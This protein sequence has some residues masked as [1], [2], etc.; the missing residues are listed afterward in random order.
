MELFVVEPSV[1]RARG[2]LEQVEIGRLSLWRAALT[3][4]H[5]RNEQVRDFRTK[6]SA[7]SHFFV[8]L[9]KPVEQLFEEPVI[10]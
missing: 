9:K 7:F 2:L 8:T 10:T 6:T 3:T 4:Q 1:H 5:I